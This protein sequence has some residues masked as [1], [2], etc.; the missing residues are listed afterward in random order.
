MDGHTR[1][2]KLIGAFHNQS[3]APIKVVHRWYSSYTQTFPGR[4]TNVE[5][6]YQRFNYALLQSTA[7]TSRMSIKTIFVYTAICGPSVT[8]VT[9]MAE[10][11]K[12]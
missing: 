10:A 11:I 8:N 9:S 12:T 3:K 6:N 7:Y 2:I 4:K 5:N 1:K